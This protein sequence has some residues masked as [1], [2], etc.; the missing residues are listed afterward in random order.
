MTQMECQPF[1]RK[2]INKW[3]YLSNQ[4]H[5]EFSPARSNLE[6]CMGE[7]QRSK[8]SLC[9]FRST[10]YFLSQVRNKPTGHKGSTIQK[11]SLFLKAQINFQ[12]VENAHNRQK[13]SSNT[14]QS[15]TPSHF[16]EVPPTAPSSVCNPQHQLLPCAT[17]Q[18][19]EPRDKEVN[20][21]CGSKRSETPI[22]K[23]MKKVL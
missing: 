11:A 17:L 3:H 15:I 19:K 7:L 6:T 16:L 9:S 1:W 18:L 20:F 8:N 22:T 10:H 23:T 2:R 13:N 5:E 21:N 12:W 14:M 4:H